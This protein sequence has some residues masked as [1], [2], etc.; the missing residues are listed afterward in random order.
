MTNIEK[1]GNQ[2]REIYERILNANNPLKIIQ[3]PKYASLVEE[4]GSKIGVLT[5]ICIEEENI[6]IFKN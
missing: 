1:Y 6:K 5:Y 3:E 2:L 4:I